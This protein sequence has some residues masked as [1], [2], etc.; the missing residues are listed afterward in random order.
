VSLAGTAISTVVVPILV[1]QRTDS[2]A[3]TGA[4]TALRVVPYLVFG[5]VAGPLADRVDRRIL[6]IWGNVAQGAA[7]AVIPLVDAVVDIPIPVVYAATFAAATAFVFTDA[8]V[9]GAL[10]VLI[11]ESRLPAANGA[12][13]SIQSAALMGGPALGGVLATTVGPANAIWVD[14]AS[15]LLAAAIIERIRAPFGTHRLVGRVRDGL[16]DHVRRGL[17]FIRHERTIFTLILVGFGNSFAF[18]AMLGLVVPYAVDRLGVPDDSARLGLLFT[19]DA[20]GALLA[21]LWF[22]RLYAPGRIRWLTPACLGIS[23]V[24]LM[25]F[26]V[27]RSYPIALGLTV[28]FAFVVSTTISVGI[29]YRQMASPDELRS[30]VNV[31]GRMVA[32]GGQPFG[33]LVGGLVAQAS[34]VPVALGVAAAVMTA[35]ALVATILLG[36]SSP[37]AAS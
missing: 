22:A 37:V 34:G 21:G 18:G 5:L 4:V 36:R 29:T 33:A 23:A 7:M 16:V 13:T 25:L 30:S 8:A 6:I 20:L 32:W 15:F 24:L 10:P 35:S 3:Q 14:V 1:F 28:G 12:L 17:R 19:A 9:F 27:I 31:V 2:P 11:G 26:V